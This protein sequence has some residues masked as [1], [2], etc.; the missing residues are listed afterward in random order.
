MATARTK[1]ERVRC[2]TPGCKRLNC[3]ETKKCGF[4]RRKDREYQTWKRRE[5]KRNAAIMQQLESGISINDICRYN[6]EKVTI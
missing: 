2:T 3:G 4:H 6:S 5:Q 1:Y